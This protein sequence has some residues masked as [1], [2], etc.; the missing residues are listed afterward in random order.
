MVSRSR[1]GRSVG[2]PH[3]GDSGDSCPPWL[4]AYR[5]SR[6]VVG[7]S[8]RGVRRFVGVRRLRDLGGI[9]GR[10]LHLRPLPVTVLL[11]GAVWRFAARLVR[12]QTW[13]VA[14]RIAVL[15]SA[16]HPALSRPV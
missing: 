12:A 4:R 6:Q 10:A 3:A 1:T 15:A 8:P 2:R 5:P 13:L 7:S 9:S 11:A 16:P 14:G